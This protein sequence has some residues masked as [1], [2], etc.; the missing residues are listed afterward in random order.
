MKWIAD[1]KQE[2]TVKRRLEKLIQMLLKG[3]REKS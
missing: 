2:E 1:A 3:K